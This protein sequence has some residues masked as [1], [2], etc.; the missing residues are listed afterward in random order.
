MLAFPFGAPGPSGPST[1]PLAAVPASVVE[2]P[3]PGPGP[4]LAARGDNLAQLTDG[5]QIAHGLGVGGNS[6]S[7]RQTPIPDP[8]ADPDLD[9][10]T[11]QEEHQAGTDPYDSDSDGGGEND[12]S[13]V[14]FS[15]DPLDPADD[16]IEA[17]ESFRASPRDGAVLLT[18]DVKAEY[19]RME[20]WRAADSPFGWVLQRGDLPLDGEH[21]APATNDTTYYYRLIGEDGAGH[22]S[23]VLDSGPVTPDVHWGYLHYL[24]L[25]ITHG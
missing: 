13:E 23:V 9:G 7:G 5:G 19:A 15:Q 6:H 10:L 22:R 11:N 1:G 3:T 4:R 2:S 16:E 24:P 8:N 12:G 25:T 20:L 21:E 14:H 17:P 18:Y